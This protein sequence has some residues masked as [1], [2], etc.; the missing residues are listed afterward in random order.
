MANK[1]LI[2]GGASGFWGEAPHAT[3][4]LLTHPGLQ[5][6]VYDYLA[7]IT[8]SIMARARLKDPSLGFANDFVSDAI[9]PHIGALSD[10]G[11]KVLSNAGGVN[12]AACADALRAAIDKAGVDLKIAVVEGDDLMDRAE[13]FAESREMFTGVPFPAAK[14]VASVNAYLGALPVV[15]AL[16]AGA[17]IVITG[18]CADSALAL[19]ACMH[20]FGWSPDDHD[21]LA[22]GSLAGHLLECG[23]QAT[24]GNFT[25]WE[26]SG[27]LADIG[28]PIAEV[29]ADGTFDI[30]KPAATT[31]IVSP[32]SVGEQM[33]YE[34]GD[35]Q[36]YVLPD[37]ICDFSEVTLTQT[38]AD[39]V[40]VAG[41]KG[42]PPTGRLKV[43]ATHMDG[44]R[45]GQVLQFNGRNARE[46]AV[47]FVNAALKR[48]RGTLE[49]LGAPDF[50]ETSVELFGGVPK[51]GRTEEISV[52]AAVRHA[53]ARAVGLFLKE[54]T[55]TALA[56]PPGLHFF[57][58]AGR[59]RPSPVVRLFSFLIDAD[60]V[61]VSIHLDGRDIASDV[62]IPARR[63]DNA[64]ARPAI[65]I[66][67]DVNEPV[68]CRLEDL[69]FARSGD[70]GDD[71]NIGVIARQ[72][73]FLPWIWRAL[74]EETIAATF[75]PNLKGGVE[76]FFLP[77]IHAMNILMHNALGGGGVASLRNDAQA[78]AFAQTL[79]ALPVELPAAL[80]DRIAKEDH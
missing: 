20:H 55:G 73:E 3:G 24:G 67:E 6:L 33:L 1:P 22:A 53:D 56:T 11:V 75:A 70:K 4:Q 58:G 61:P 63:E 41:V 19:A 44:Y 49:R 34:I 23:P 60:K 26:Q 46:K 64:P 43:S 79:L 17:D 51:N 31:G 74:D 50:A 15:A 48:T 78:K 45:A 66:S 5:Y 57:T 72:P 36:G 25:D 71:A 39:R 10:R 80:A 62:A 69:A 32:G 68:S 21:L 30:V 47:A 77:G 12:P 37:V 18:R 42:R 29:E 35:P 76:R 8:M 38:A 27:D 13:M 59:P 9:A 14:S 28:Y 52:K 40:H 16:D 2:I 54:M 7:E 65:S